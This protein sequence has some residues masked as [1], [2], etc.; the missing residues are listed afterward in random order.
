MNVSLHTIKTLRELTG[1]GIM[2]CK[3]ALEESGGDQDRARELL[4]QQGISVVGKKST[5][6]TD[7]GVIDIYLHSGNR[8]GAMVELN[9]E[10]DFVGRTP[11][12]RELAHDIAMQVAA[13]SPTNVASAAEATNSEESALLGQ[14]F[15][16]DPTKTIQDLI[17]DVIGKVGENIRVARFVRFAIGEE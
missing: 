12:F 16:K 3:R 14:V 7:E 9:C 10:T 4:K 8:I 1:A 13:M 6:V 17:N 2:D 5:R 11:E 15:I